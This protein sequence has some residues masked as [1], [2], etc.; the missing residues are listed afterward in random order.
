T[1]IA[2]GIR[3]IP[4]RERALKEMLRVTVPGGQVM[5]L[6]MTFVRNRF[7]KFLYHVYLNRLLPLFAKIF[8]T[9]PAAYYYLADSIMNFP[10]PAALAGLMQGSGIKDVKIH[11]LTFGI[12]YLH[13]G[14]KP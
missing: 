3:N 13:I 10:S 9:N 8:S 4:D 11:S 14:E 12:T 2:F 5:V 1:A 6:E 7:F